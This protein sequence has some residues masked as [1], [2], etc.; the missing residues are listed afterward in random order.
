MK[1]FN[2]FI[3]SLLYSFILNGQVFFYINDS[4]VDIGSN[5][6]INVLENDTIYT[7]KGTFPVRIHKDVDDMNVVLFEFKY[8]NYMFE[9]SLDNMTANNIEYYKKIWIYYYSKFTQNLK[10]LPIENVP[11]VLFKCDF[12]NTLISFP[13]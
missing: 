3:I 11:V 10:E 12:C 1:R 8:E 9:F 5:Y 6:S 2:I 7:Y 4:I 13:Q